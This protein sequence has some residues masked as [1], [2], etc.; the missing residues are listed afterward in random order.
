MI[1]EGTILASDVIK[2]PS[3]NKLQGQVALCL[4]NGTWA[5]GFLYNLS[6][7]I[8][9]VTVHSNINKWMTTMQSF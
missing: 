4:F 9:N 3:E 6:E 2:L 7:S 1:R 8:L 5:Q